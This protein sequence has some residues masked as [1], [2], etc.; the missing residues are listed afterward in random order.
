MVFQYIVIKREDPNIA[1]VIMQR[2]RIFIEEDNLIILLVLWSDED[3]SAL[4]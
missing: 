2:Y 4:Y 3:G 1:S